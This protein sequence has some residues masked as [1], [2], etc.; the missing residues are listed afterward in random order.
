MTEFEKCL[1]ISKMNPP[2]AG[3]YKLAKALEIYLKG[4]LDLLQG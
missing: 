2:Y 1:K 4:L 3:I